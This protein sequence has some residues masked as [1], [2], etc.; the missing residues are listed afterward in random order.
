VPSLRTQ[1]HSDFVHR[2]MQTYRARLRRL[3]GC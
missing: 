1:T 2:D 3:G